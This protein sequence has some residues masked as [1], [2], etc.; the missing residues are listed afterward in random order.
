[1]HCSSQFIN[2]YF[3]LQKV[4]TKAMSSFL[5]I[6]APYQL[7]LYL[8]RELYIIFQI[9]I[10][11]LSVVGNIYIYLKKTRLIENKANV[12]KLRLHNSVI[13]YRKI[14]K[15]KLKFWENIFNWLAWTLNTLLS[16][17]R[18]I[19]DDFYEVVFPTNR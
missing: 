7:N 9:T 8:S 19:A 2:W 17:W 15:K 18:N 13:L 12:L 3:W 14:I 11:I 16:K 10:V 5:S 4:L 1:M 6:F